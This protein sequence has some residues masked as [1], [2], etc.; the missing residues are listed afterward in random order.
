MNR[1]VQQLVYNRDLKIASNLM[2]AC[3]HPLRLQLISFIHENKSINVNSIYQ[4]LKLEQSVAS[5]HLKILRDANLVLTNRQGK[6]IFYS[7]NYELLEQIA[8]S[9]QKYFPS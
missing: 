4:T 2:R 7:L 1:A 6:F 9:T 5:Q 8:E 3:T